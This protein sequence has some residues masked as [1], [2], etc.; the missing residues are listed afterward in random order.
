MLSGV[1]EPEQ[2]RGAQVSADF[3]KVLGVEPAIGRSFMAHED[4]EGSDGV[5]LLSHGLWARRFGA[6]REVIGKKITLNLHPYTVIGVL[7]S[8]FDL[9]DSKTEVWIPL[10]VDPQMRAARGALWL[11]VVA[12]LKNGISI[13]QAKAQ[14][15]SLNRDLG[16][17]FPASDKRAGTVVNRLRDDATENVRMPVIIVS[18]AVVCVLLIACA[19]VASMMLARAAG[20]GREIS[21]RLAVGAGTTRIVRQLLTESLTLFV[22]GGWP[23]SSPRSGAS[24]NWCDSLLL[25][26][27]S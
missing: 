23:D 13:Q 7:P 1:D 11:A 25:R 2:L 8:S 9:P 21:V 10:A 24:H 16:E 18:F 12:R 26:C 5:V 3:F 19:N 20:R 14:L 27:P 17:K 22:A 15:D 6:G 4:Q